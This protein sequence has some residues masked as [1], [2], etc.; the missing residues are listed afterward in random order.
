MRQVFE[1]TT[2][3]GLRLANRLVRSATWEGLGDADGRV[4]EG[5]IEIYRRLAEGGVGLIITGY[6]AVR[7][8]AASTRSGSALTA[9]SCPGLAGARGRGP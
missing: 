7:S 5:V 1:A 8:T 2:I 3:N 9:T 6:L 4:N